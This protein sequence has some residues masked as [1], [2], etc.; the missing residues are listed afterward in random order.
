MED[1]DQFFETLRAKAEQIGELQKQFAGD[2][3][4]IAELSAE[5]VAAVDAFPPNDSLTKA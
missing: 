1:L 5:L 3:T 2:K 4:A